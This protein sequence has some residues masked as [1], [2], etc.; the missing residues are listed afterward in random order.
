MTATNIPFQS[1]GSI[2]IQE[3]VIFTDEGKFLDVKDFIAELNIYEDLYAPFLQGVF[4]LADSRN[5]VKE[6]PIVGEEYFYIKMKTPNTDSFIEKMF[7]IY[8]VTDR[9]VVKDR[10]TQIY[11]LNF[12]SVEAVVNTFKPI[13]KTFEGQISEIVKTIFDDYIQVPGAPTS[14]SYP[15]NSVNNNLLDEHINE[16][17]KISEHGITKLLRSWQVLIKGLDETKSGTNQIEIVSIIIVKLCYTSS[18]P[19]PEELIKKLDK[20]ISNNSSNKTSAKTIENKSIDQ[21]NTTS[22]PLE[23]DKTY[24]PI[25]N[26]NT[27][28][29]EHKTNIENK[30]SLNNFEELLT[31]LIE[32]REAL[33]HA[34]LVNNVVIDSFE[35]G[36]ISMKISENCSFDVAKHL[37]KFLQDKTGLKWVIEEVKKTDNKTHEE[38][39]DINFE[40]KKKEI[41]SDPIINEVKQLFPNAEI[42]DIE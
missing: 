4:I 21:K 31:F 13:F 37:S 40:K 24:Q 29:I 8:S 18:T 15:N 30:I 1:A 39:K 27:I 7:R 41:E 33:L 25:K 19:M 10:N 16:F 32:N 14:G 12:I 17:K 9:E 6:F 22:E 3:V 36:K 20:K 28:D 23:S 42:K 2:D 26:E 35:N 38:N 34:Q 5:L 11:N